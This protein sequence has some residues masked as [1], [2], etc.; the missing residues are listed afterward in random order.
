M[1]TNEVS[2]RKYQQEGI[3]K[4]AS[5]IR[6]RYHKTARKNWEKHSPRTGS[7]AAKASDTTVPL[8]TELGKLVPTVGGSMTPSAVDAEGL[9]FWAPSG[10]LSLGDVG[11]LQMLDEM[12]AGSETLQLKLEKGRGCGYILGVWLRINTLQVRTQDVTYILVAVITYHTSISA[13]HPIRPHRVLFKR[14]IYNPP[15]S[16]SRD[17]WLGDPPNVSYI[18]GIHGDALSPRQKREEHKGLPEP[19]DFMAEMPPW[20]IPMASELN[21]TKLLELA[22]REVM[23]DIIAAWSPCTLDRKAGTQ[24]GTSAGTP[25]GAAAS[26][27]PLCFHRRNSM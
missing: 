15:N 21:E 19:I 11:I 4:K 2:T 10:L 16:D 12:F 25:A 22:V 3:K 17:P 9:G 26:G 20:A 14:Q 24:P 23:A 8:R 7:R 5:R 6:I 18:H 27:P 1:R 13:D